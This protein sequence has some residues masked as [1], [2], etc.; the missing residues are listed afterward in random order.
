[1][2]SSR[3]LRFCLV[4]CSDIAKKHV[5][6]LQRLSE[7]ELVAVCDLNKERALTLAKQ[8]GA[9]PYTD[10]HTM[11]TSEDV[12]VVGILTPSGDHA[13][14]ILEVV[15]YRKHIVVE[16]PLALRLDDADRVIRTCDEAGVRLFVVKQNRFNR[17]IQALKRAIERGRFGKLVLGTVRVRW[18]RPPAYYKSTPWRGTWAWDGGVLTNQASHHIDMLEWM[19]GEVESVTAMTCTRLAK[20]EAED[21]AVAI[22]RFRNGALGVI[23]ATTATRPIDLEGSISIL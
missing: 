9:R 14:R 6:A 22:L 8:C 20:I 10:L 11:L 18:C 16:K 17:P 23:E 15:Q 12:D 13:E 4:G 2:S 3:P 1:M 5:A 7:A 21:T 19:M